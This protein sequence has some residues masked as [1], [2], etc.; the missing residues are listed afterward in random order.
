MFTLLEALSIH[1]PMILRM[2]EYLR[3]RMG[4]LNLVKLYKNVEGKEEH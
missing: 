2:G 3:L 1:I 4:D